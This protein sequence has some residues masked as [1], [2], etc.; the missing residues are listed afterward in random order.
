MIVKEYETARTFL[1]NNENILLEHEA[2]SQLIL[3]NAYQNLITFESG[4]GMF[5]AVL[6]EENTVL[7]F[8]NVKPYS[9]VIYIAC[10]DKDMVNAASITVADFFA[11]NHIPITGIIAKNSVCQSFINH[12]KKCISCNFNEIRGMDIM[13]I[14]K[15]NEIKPVEGIHRTAVNAESKVI[16]DWMI[17]FQ[18]EALSSEINYEVAL[19]KVTNLINNNKIFVY[20]NIEH[21]IVSMAT[22]TRKLIHGIA[23]SYV[24]TPEEFRGK[25]YA[26]ANI[27]YLSKELLEGGYDFC[28]LFADKKNLVSNRAYE[29]VGYISMEENYEYKVMPIVG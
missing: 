6:E 21:R 22:V 18:I 1:N 3:F 17:Q 16:T 7:L 15:V 8:C 5:G 24:F 14:R 23:I 11:D 25:G 28:T 4:K 19:K 20:E 12:F 26:A 9:L 27:Y 2:I 13:E 10:Q 29:K